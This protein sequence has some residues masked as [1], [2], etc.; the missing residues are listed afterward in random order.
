MHYQ[1]LTK[2]ALG[3][4]LL[5]LLIPSV[6]LAKDVALV[7]DPNTGSDIAGYRLYVREAD[8]PYDYNFPEWQGAENN[9]TVAQLDGVED[10]Y[11]VVRAFT[12][13]GVEST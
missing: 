3:I 5:L 12:V 4:I 2:S 10:Y 11:F 1:A 7:W 13:D 6:C 9:C 8:E